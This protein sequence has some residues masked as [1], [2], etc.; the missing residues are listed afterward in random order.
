MVRHTDT[1]KRINRL[2]ILLGILFLLFGTLVYFID[3]SPEH[4]YFFHH[5]KFIKT[6]H[7]TLPALFGPIGN[8][9]PDLIH[10]LSFIL[11]TAG[12][13]SCGKRGYRIICLSWLTIDCIFELGQKY[14]TQFI[15]VV[16]DWFKGIPFLEAFE[17]YF[18]KGTYDPYDIAA[19][20]AGAILAYFILILTANMRNTQKN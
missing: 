9:L 4:T 11:I 12:I 6:L 19:I 20:L 13:I 15:K 7:N 18:K 1:Q 2:Q 17:S 5:Y 8:Y 14:S 16:P 10:P 3:R